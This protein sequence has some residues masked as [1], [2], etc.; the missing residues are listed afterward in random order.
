ML[1]LCPLNDIIKCLEAEQHDAIA[2]LFCFLLCLLDRSRKHWCRLNAETEL[3]QTGLVLQGE[4]GKWGQRAAVRPW[5]NIMEGGE[6]NFPHPP[7]RLRMEYFFFS[8]IFANLWN[9]AVLT[10]PCRLINVTRNQSSWCSRE[11]VQLIW[12]EKKPQKRTIRGIR[13][14][15]KRYA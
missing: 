13:A 5:G 6:K 7:R 14:R 9:L 4:A 3:V 10:V 11:E 12:G 2:C 1:H 15:R 8:F